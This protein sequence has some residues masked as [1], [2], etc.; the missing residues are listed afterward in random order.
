M[1]TEQIKR[2]Y[3]CGITDRKQLAERFSTTEKYVAKVI[4]EANLRPRNKRTL[5]V[6]SYTEAV[7]LGITSV[8]DLANYFKVSSKTIKRFHSI[9]HI[10]KKISEYFH[11]LNRPTQWGNTGNTTIN[12]EQPT[13]KDVCNMLSDIC[14][15]I[16]PLANINKQ[17]ARNL[18]II[19]DIIIKIKQIKPYKK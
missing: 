6:S 7:F 17:A 13:L 18:K 3:V 11:V 5:T 15:S 14:S 10:R 16:E 9:S 4:R 1:K 19:N 8:N 2:A 12:P